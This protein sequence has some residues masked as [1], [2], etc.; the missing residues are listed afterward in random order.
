M[1]GKTKILV[2]GAAGFIGSHLCEALVNKGHRVVGM[3]GPQC[4]TKWIK[5]LDMEFIPADIIRKETLYTAVKDVKYIYHLAAL[6]ACSDS[7]KLFQTNLQ[8]T[9][10]LVDACLEIEPKIEKFLFTS[11]AKIV[12][13]TAPDEIFTE[14]DTCR[15]VS[16]YGRS[17][18]LA[19][20]YLESKRDALP[21]TIVRLPLVYGPRNLAGLYTAFKLIS[22]GIRIDIGLGETNVGYV[23]DIIEGIIQAAESPLT[24]GQRYFIGEDRATS[25]DDWY[26]SMEAAL[27]K[28]TV[29]IKPPYPLIFLYAFFSELYTNLRRAVPVLTRYN[30]RYIKKY[31]ICRIGMEKAARDFGYRTRIPLNQGVAI[32]AQ[33]YK[34][35]G[36]L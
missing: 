12:G 2:T 20:E 25:V 30:L 6:R 14:T 29:R 26:T 10:N 7:E 13:P 23:S 21:F 5:D 27:N 35:H 18:L 9:K 22:R 15:P 36:Y 4:D 31:P 28:K 34:D 33:W 3:I 16:D 8:G 32:T 19:E 17:K 24:T 1:S 11:S